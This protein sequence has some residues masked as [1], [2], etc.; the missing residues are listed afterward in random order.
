MEF[1]R[2]PPVMRQ[3]TRL[4]NKYWSKYTKYF[5]VPTSRYLPSPL[6]MHSVPNL[7]WVVLVDFSN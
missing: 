5:P 7:P 6:F 3:T 2:K 4:P 1:E